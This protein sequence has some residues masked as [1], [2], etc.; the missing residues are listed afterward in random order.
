MNYIFINGIPMNAWPPSI[1]SRL[2]D[3]TEVEDVEY[4]EVETKTN[5]NEKS[6]RN[7]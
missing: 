2:C 5:D 1:I 3:L 7:N 6:E 4:V